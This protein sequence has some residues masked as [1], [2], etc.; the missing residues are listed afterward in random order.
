M[1]DSRL[2]RGERR[3]RSRP[4]LQEQVA[5]LRDRLRVGDLEAAQLER[6]AQLGSRA[7]RLALQ[8]AAPKRIATFEG[9]VEFV[10]SQGLDLSLRLC[11]A[12]LEHGLSLWEVQPERCERH[13][14][15]RCE[16]ATCQ[17]DPA[18][19]EVWTQLHACVEAGGHSDL[20]QVLEACEAAEQ[21]VLSDRGQV[22]RLR[23]E[24]VVTYD[25]GERKAPVACAASWATKACMAAFGADAE[26]RRAI[27]DGRHM[28]PAGIPF[29]SDGEQSRNA[30]PGDPEWEIV[31]WSAVAV[32][33]CGQS[34]SGVLVTVRATAR[35]TATAKRQPVDYVLD[36][37]LHSLRE[38]V[39]ELLAE[40]V[41]PTGPS[42]GPRA[43]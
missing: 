5:L 31:D 24:G 25:E 37:T 18:L 1:A 40:R 20:L 34:V 21:A 8:D 16:E 35:E 6:A 15:L 41:L 22:S 23:G 2:Q 26:R 19:R 13:G 3:A 36:E 28:P 33:F 42:E 12:V 14:A 29:V 9:W 43:P 10:L 30:R 11:L 4:A 7:A 32:G 38:A 39:G 17:L 27:A